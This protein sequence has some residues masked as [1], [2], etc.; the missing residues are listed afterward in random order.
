MCVFFLHFFNF[1]KGVGVEGGSSVCPVLSVAKATLSPQITRLQLKIRFV[2][3]ID[4]SLASSR[5]MAEMA[6][7]N[8]GQR[9]IS[10]HFVHASTFPGL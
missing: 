1:K 2:A 9:A 6:N 4:C 7:D 10:E 3:A 5:I 8:G